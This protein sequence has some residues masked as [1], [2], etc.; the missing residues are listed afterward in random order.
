MT[1]RKNVK[2]FFRGASAVQ[3][4]MQKYRGVRGRSWLTFPSTLEE[5]RQWTNDHKLFPSFRRWGCPRGSWTV[6]KS[7][8]PP[9]A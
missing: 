8:F 9:F 2:D 4:I 1:D 7:L 5:C 6:A 3:S